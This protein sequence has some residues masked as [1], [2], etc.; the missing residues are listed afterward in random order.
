M[1]ASGAGFGGGAMSV[2][3]SPD[4]GFW[5]IG[6]KEVYRYD[7][8]GL[9][10]GYVDFV[11]EKIDSNPYFSQKGSIVTS[12]NE[13]VTT[14]SIVLVH[15]KQDGFYLIKI[16]KSGQY[17]T[18]SFKDSNLYGAYEPSTYRIDDDRVMFQINAIQVENSL[19]LVISKLPMPIG[20][21]N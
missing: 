7:S 5:L 20:L 4:A 16:D 14:N 17:Q 19:D 11:K 21:N 2:I 1:G 13:E 10:T 9:R 8:T 3:K 15:Q 6:S 12:N 18:L